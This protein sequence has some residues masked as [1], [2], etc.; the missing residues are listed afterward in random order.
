MNKKKIKSVFILLL[1]SIIWGTTFSAQSMG[2]ECIGPFSFNTYRS[3]MAFI[4]LFI[5]SLFLNLKDKTNKSFSLYDNKDTYICGIICGILLFTA[6]TLQQIGISY[7]SVGKSGFITSLY[8]IIV[9][10]LSIFKRKKIALRTWLCVILVVIG[11]YFLCLNESLKLNIGDVL[12]FFCAIVFS[13][14]ILV[15]NMYSERIHTIKMSCVQFLT[16][17]IFS[18]ICMLIF[19]NIDFTLVKPVLMPLL[20]AGILSS[21]VAYTLQIYAQKNTDPISASLIMSLESVFAL[22]SGLLF[23]KQFL[24]VKEIIG[25]AIIFLSIVI[26]QLPY[27]IKIVKRFSR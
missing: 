2:A 17:F 19:E 22:L 4:F 25:C 8:V 16:F 11:L 13:A 10:L 9:P 1:V 23:L 20:F 26:S 24:T 12:T 15:I 3:F 5:I 21:G 6:S 14:G 7:T 18:F 27:K